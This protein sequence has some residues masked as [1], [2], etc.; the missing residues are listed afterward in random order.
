VEE[1]AVTVHGGA[2]GLSEHV[3]GEAAEDVH[4]HVVRQPRSPSS[5]ASIWGLQIDQP[6]WSARGP[7]I[8]QSS[9]VE[10][11]VVRACVSYSICIPIGKH[12]LGN[13]LWS[14]WCRL[15]VEQVVCVAG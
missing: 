8:N 4:E 5:V 12:K 14:F 15:Q 9:H 6:G 1:E 3:A 10:I 13:C 11:V 2:P 7:W